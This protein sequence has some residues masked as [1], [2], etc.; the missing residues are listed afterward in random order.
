MSKESQ[1][2]I[3]FVIFSLSYVAAYFESLPLNKDI[4]I[5][6]KLDVI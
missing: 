1:L 5:Y 4:F 6:F 3:R 2:R